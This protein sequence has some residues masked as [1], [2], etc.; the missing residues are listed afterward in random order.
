MQGIVLKRLGHN[1]HIYEQVTESTR[2]SE[3]A[4][5]RAGPQSQEFLDK[6]DLTREPW[7]VLSPAAKIIR[8][9]S[10]TMLNLKM[11]MQ[12]TSWSTLYYRLRANFDGLKS[13]YCPNPPGPLDSDGDVTYS[14]G[15][16]ILSSAWD[17][18]R[19]TIN[20]EDVRDGSSGIYS[21]DLVIVAEGSRSLMRQSMCD[22]PRDYAGY[23]AWRGCVVESELSEETRKVIG[24]QLTF[25][26]MKDSY[27]LV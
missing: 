2:Q 7:A 27:I 4:G 19:L 6:Y 22:L 17:G 24:D 5:M 16:R 9:D 14:P 18:E 21:P 1:V 8:K 25:F 13:D 20:V 12:M 10:S 23:V 26:T 3:A 11:P 15:K